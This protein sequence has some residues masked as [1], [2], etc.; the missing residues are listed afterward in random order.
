MNFN[1][2]SPGRRDL[3]TPAARL[4]RRKITGK[5]AIKIGMKHAHTWNYDANSG[6]NLHHKSLH[7]TKSTTQIYENGSTNV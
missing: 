2:T 3:Q 1:P 4:S 6:E 5:R 7:Q